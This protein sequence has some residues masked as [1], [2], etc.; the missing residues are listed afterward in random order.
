MRPL[1]FQTVRRPP[2]THCAV[3]ALHGAST[4]LKP[5]STSGAASGVPMVATKPRCERALVSFRLGALA[6]DVSRD[7]ITG[8]SG[9]VDTAIRKFAR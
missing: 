1:R 8:G 7:G 9:Q 5:A 3:T 2:L 4:R 6:G